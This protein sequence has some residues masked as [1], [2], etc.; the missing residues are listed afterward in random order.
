MFPTLF[1][2]EFTR[3]DVTVSLSGDGG[4]E[5][6]GGYPRHKI[7]AQLMFM[8]KVPASVRKALVKILPKSRLKQ[9]IKAS[10]LDLEQ[11]YSESRE[12]VYKPEIY[13]KIMSE[14][15]KECLDLADGDL[16]EAMIL[17]DRYFNTLPDNYLTKVDRASMANA[18]E[19]RCPFLDYRLMEYASKIPSEL[20]ASKSKNK[21]LMKELIEGIVPNEIINRKKA[22]FTP[23][24]GEWLTKEEYLNEMTLALDDLNKRGM[25][26]DEWKTFYQQRVLKRNDLL[27]Q[28]YKIR[29]FLFNRW[30]QFWKKKLN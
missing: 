9:G 22:G 27:S 16:V 12:D 8:K 7:A 19:V 1:L 17:M 28:N 26:T 15:L 20:K 3:K 6:F 11:M 18:L 29:L 30:Y 24:I 13:K 4:D 23:P 21:I 10:F 25:I 14:K 2:S 5:I